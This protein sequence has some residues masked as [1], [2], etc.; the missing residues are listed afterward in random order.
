MEPQATC[1]AGAFDDAPYTH[2]GVLIDFEP[3]VS[4]WD[5]GHELGGK[6]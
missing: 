2:L 3:D 1:W 5:T 6:E 4:E